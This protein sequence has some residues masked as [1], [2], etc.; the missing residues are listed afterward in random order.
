MRIAVFYEFEGCD[1][2]SNYCTI[3]RASHSCFREEIDTDSTL[4]M[5][6][7]NIKILFTPD[8]KDQA[9]ELKERLEKDGVATFV[10]D[11]LYVTMK[12]KIDGKEVSKIVPLPKDRI[13]MTMV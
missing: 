2:L 10:T 1:T 6:K 8:T 5:M 12:E 13:V 3:D 7:K 9:Y 4:Q 11:Q